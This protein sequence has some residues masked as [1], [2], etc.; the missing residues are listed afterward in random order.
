LALGFDRI[1]M[2]LAQTSS[3]RDVIA[4]PKTQQA[5][6]LLTDAPSEVDPAQLR[7][8]RIAIRKTNS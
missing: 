4:F 3:I 8:L 7:D 1:I 5:S 6:C 2:L